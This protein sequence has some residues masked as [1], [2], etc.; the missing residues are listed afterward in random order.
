MALGARNVRRA[1]RVVVIVTLALLV[2]VGVMWV[3]QR[4]FI[5]FPS[6][7]LPEMAVALP[8]AEEVRFPTE[9]GLTLAAWLVPVAGD[10]NGGTVVVFNGNAG[11]RG[12]RTPLA[13]AMAESGYRVLLIDYRGYGGNPGRPTEEGLLADGRAAVAYLETR[14]DVDTDRLVNRS[15]LANRDRCVS[16]RIRCR[17]CGTETS[18]RTT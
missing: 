9:D 14:P 7:V 6:Q 16:T 1:A 4:R 3:L 8:G 11:N 17:S 18:S 12:D 2:A 13:Q 15:A 5:Y 10:A